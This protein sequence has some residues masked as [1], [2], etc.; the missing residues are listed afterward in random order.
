VIFVFSLAFAIAVSENYRL[1]SLS[2]QPLSN[3]A[4]F[5]LDS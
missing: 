1:V 4:W 2:M 5:M 3:L